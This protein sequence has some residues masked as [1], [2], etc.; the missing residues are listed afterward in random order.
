MKKVTRKMRRDYFWS[1]LAMFLSVSAVY[2]LLVGTDPNFGTNIWQVIGIGCACGYGFTS[3]VHG[4]IMFIRWISR[5]GLAAKILCGLFF[6]L[7]FAAIVYVGIFSFLPYGIY[8]LVMLLTG[9]GK[10]AESSSSDTDI[11]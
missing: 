8:N 2:G 1:T 7:S 10:Q 4:T 11:H 5:R 9:K 3:L 6:L